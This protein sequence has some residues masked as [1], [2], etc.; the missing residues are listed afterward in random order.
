MS[1]AVAKPSTDELDELTLKRAQRGDDDA[2][3]ALV[4]RYEKPVFALIS[5]MLGQ[6]RRD[7]VE[8]LA[9]ETFLAV[10]R[11]LAGFSALGKARLSTWVLTIASRRTVDE[12]RKRRP[13]TSPMMLDSAELASNARADETAR[14]RDIARAIQAAIA[15][16][17]PAYRAAF[18]LREY[19]GLDYAEISRA[20]DIDKGTVKSRLA[21]ART[22]LRAALA[23]VHDD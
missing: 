4:A 5:R 18:L 10:F 3:R 8:D 22:A 11:S 17:A 14:R 7:L 19:H 9:Q 15:E 2:C 23:E 1:H 16:L 21:R 12:L 6:G 13:A 20:L